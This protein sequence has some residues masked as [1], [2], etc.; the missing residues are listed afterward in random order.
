M[1]D[2]IVAI[3]TAH[4]V[5]S[6]AIVRLSGEQALHFATKITTKQTFTPR[7]ATLTTLYDSQKQ[8]I[9][10]ALV[11]YFKAPNSYTAEDVVEF[12][13]HGGT[14]IATRLINELIALGARMANPGE[15]TK[16]A[17]LNGRIDLSEAEAIGSLINAKSEQATQVLLKQLKGE[18]KTFVETI[19]ETFLN[20][21]A[22][23]EVSIDYAEE[24]LPVTIIQTLEERLEGVKK[25]L[26]DLLVAS[27]TRDGLMQGFNVAIVGKP[28]VGKSSLLNNLLHFN[29][30]I[31]S[32]IAGTTRDTIEAELKI[33]SHHVNVIDTA[34]IRKTEDVIETI[35]IERS[36][37]M[38]EEADIV[39]AMFDGSRVTS[40]EDGD[41]IALI[42]SVKAEKRVFVLINKSD[43]D[44]QFD[45]SVLSAYTP[46]GIT[47][48]EQNS[49]LINAMEQH[50]DSINSN[51][52]MMLVSSRQI[53]AVEKTIQ[54]IDDAFMP[55]HSQELEF[56]SFH[57]NEAIDH[58]SSISAPY[59]LDQMFDKMFGE[60]CLGK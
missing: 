30:A 13:C 10:E 57:I 55:L 1:N 6:I 56:F 29:R 53:Q 15:F 33:G 9:D 45:K 18:V 50:L 44:Q 5:G 25:A 38:V 46:I 39:L 41:V 28:N 22:Y 8:I 40:D 4:G 37:Q 26:D 27:K 7:Y 3:A 24:D 21:L 12:Q 35:G 11:L 49:D 58:I 48:H 23:S 54:A 31:V 47:T 20:I 36:R 19:R 42:D 51:D 2:T 34:G 60:F 52:E 14:V 43:L 32:E 59:E 17:F 16:R